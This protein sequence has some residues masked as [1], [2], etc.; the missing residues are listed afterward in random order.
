MD[1]AVAFWN[2]L[3]T[4]LSSDL[5]DVAWGQALKERGLPGPWGSRDSVFGVPSDDRCELSGWELIIEEKSETLSYW[6]WRRPLRAG[7]YMYRTHSVLEDMSAADLR[8][9]QLD[10]RARSVAIY[11]IPP[12]FGGL[13]RTVT[14]RNRTSQ[15]TSDC[16]L[17]KFMFLLQKILYLTMRNPTRR[18]CVS[19]TASP[20]LLSCANLRFQNI[21]PASDMCV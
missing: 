5:F 11:V 8:V 15:G 9:F 20:T 2:V 10:D 17:E 13:A 14:L 1:R 3:S 7:L 18:Q 12:P 19:G 6:A 4:F 16:Y 21:Y